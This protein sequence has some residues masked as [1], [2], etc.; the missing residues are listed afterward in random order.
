MNNAD[1]TLRQGFKLLNRVMVPVWRLGL[2]GIMNMGPENA[3]RYLVIT[4]TGRKSGLPHRTPLNFG[5][6]DGEIYVVAGF[7][8]TADWYRN[9]MADPDA[10]IWLGSEWWQARAEDFSSAPNRIEIMRA[11]LTGS[12]FAAR[13]AGINPS[14]ISD[15]ELDEKTRDYRIVHLRKVAPRTGLGG[16]GDLAWVWP[17]A[18]LLL[19][20][21]GRRRKGWF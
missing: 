19:L 20:L 14:A 12:G 11:V 21:R 8:S 17:V 16:P 2:G 18:T 6:V 13:V 9:L 15:Q 5:T 3:G 10:E 4:H 7:G 1:E